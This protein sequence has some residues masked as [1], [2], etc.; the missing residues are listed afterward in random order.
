MSGKLLRIIFMVLLL[1]AMARAA[2]EGFPLRKEFPELATISTAELSKG[3][4]DTVIVDVRSEFEFDTIHINGSLFIPVSTAK[5]T[6]SLLEKVPKSKKVAFYCNG[7]A[8][9]K[10]YQ[11]A[12]QAI[13][14]G[15]TRALVYDD[16][17]FEWAKAN[18][19]KA[20]FLGKTPVDVNMLMATK[21]DFVNRALN[22]E[23]FRAKAAKPEAILIDIR[24]PYQRTK[25]S[26][27]NVKI[28]LPEMPIKIRYTTLD[29]FQD[30]IKK[31]IYKDKLLLVY[32]ATG[33]Q[34]QWL[35]YHLRAAGYK[36]YYFLKGGVF[37]VTGISAN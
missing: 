6:E 36:D 4:K 12:R 16:G 19:D 9:A 18:P 23:D 21:E 22:F 25:E 32:D 10:S 8:C 31:E 2:D 37:E 33:K 28:E 13:K 29:K 7:H 3:Y 24:E 30:L 1:P 17:I 26:D 11:A 15:Y 34:V 20:T 14:D 35:Q 27:R 5:F